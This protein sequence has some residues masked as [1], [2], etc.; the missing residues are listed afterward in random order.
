[1][2]FDEVRFPLRVR[3]D[4]LLQSLQKTASS[5]GKLC[6]T[7]HRFSWWTFERSL[8]VPHANLIIATRG[9]NGVVSAP[10]VYPEVTQSI[11]FLFLFLWISSSNDWQRDQADATL[12]FISSRILPDDRCSTIYTFPEVPKLR[13]GS[14]SDHWK[15]RMNRSWCWYK[16][17]GA[18]ALSR[19]TIN[20]RN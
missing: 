8:S 4:W 3:K 16:I 1:M 7:D 12:V 20:S 11:A 14:S 15:H 18:A 6:S 13:S 2:E 17:A 9:K 10:A 19:H 5:D